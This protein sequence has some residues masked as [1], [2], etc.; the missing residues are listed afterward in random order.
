VATRNQKDRQIGALFRHHV[1]KL[2]TIRSRHADIGDEQVQIQE[3]A[4]Q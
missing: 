4:G 3:P 2:E 1:A